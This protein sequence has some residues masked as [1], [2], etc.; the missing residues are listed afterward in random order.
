MRCQAP[1]GVGVC[2]LICSPARTSEPNVPMAARFLKALAT[3]MES[4]PRV[5]VTA[6][7]MREE[8]QRNGV[9]IDPAAPI[10][11]VETGQEARERAARGRLVVCPQPELI[12]QGA[13]I[14]VFVAEGRFTVRYSLPNARKAGATIPEMVVKLG[15][16]HISE[17]IS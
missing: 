12:D 1:I 3:G 15:K 8:L 5:A 2:L 17:P 4:P 7:A 6:V 11:W 14:A 9:A 10:V 16:P 13:A